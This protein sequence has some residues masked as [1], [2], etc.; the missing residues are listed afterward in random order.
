MWRSCSY[1]RSW[2]DWEKITIHSTRTAVNVNQGSQATHGC[3]VIIGN[4]ISPPG[5]AKYP[6]IT[7]EEQEFST[8]LQILYLAIMDTWGCPRRKHKTGQSNNKDRMMRW[9]ELEAAVKEDK[10]ES[11]YSVFSV[12]ADLQKSI[13]VRRIRRVPNKKTKN[14][15]LP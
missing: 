15:I 1:Q 4:L 13:P 7:I 14:L 11:T 12:T 2:R 5:R 8:A 10:R 3:P 9:E 6:A